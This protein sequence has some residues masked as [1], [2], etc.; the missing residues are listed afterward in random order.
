[1]KILICG[2]GAIGSNLTARLVADLKGEHAITLLD[3]DTVEER[4]VQAGTQFYTPD[5]IGMLKT[6]ALQF[7]LY[8]WYQRRTTVRNE[9]ILD[10]SALDVDDYDLVID[11]FDNT[12]ARN[13]LFSFGSR[14][15]TE[16]LHVGFS[17]NF[18]FAIEW[19]DN[20]V[21]PTDINGLDI[22]EL[23]GA[24]AFVNI[25]SSMGAMVAEEYVL[26]K[27]KMEVTGGKFVHTLIK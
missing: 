16:V 7:N 19:N 1:M 4:N 21:V 24:A 3:Y 26:K 17:D 8:K 15:E 13:R 23:P 22:C 12:R 20:Y 25:V 10:V 11:C 6:E 18:T 27:N 2:L 9:N 14:N 5:Q